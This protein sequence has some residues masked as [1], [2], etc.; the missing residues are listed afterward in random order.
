MSD[1]KFEGKKDDLRES[2]ILFVIFTGK[3]HRRGRQISE[4]QSLAGEYVT[5]ETPNVKC[6]EASRTMTK[7]G[8]VGIVIEDTRMWRNSVEVANQIRDEERRKAY[9]GKEDGSGKGSEKVE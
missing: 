6:R 9:G 7:I 4:I 1:D 8:E 3:D 2:R 5:W